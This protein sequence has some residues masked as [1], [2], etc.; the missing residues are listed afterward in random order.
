[1]SQVR[2]RR[3][4]TSENMDPQ[5]DTRTAAAAVD[6]GSGA[7]LGDLTRGWACSSCGVVTEDISPL[8]PEGVIICEECAEPPRYRCQIIPFVEQFR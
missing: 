1:M 4:A 8:G 3:A 7:L 2:Q 5:T 6:L